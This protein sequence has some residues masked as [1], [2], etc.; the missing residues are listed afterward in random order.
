MVSEFNLT[1]ET[2]SNWIRMGLNLLAMFFS[3]SKPFK[4]ILPVISREMM[5]AA[6]TISKNQISIIMNLATKGI[7]LL[8]VFP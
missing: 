8:Y 7:R 4:L 2:K 6:M 3:Y 1:T 5:I